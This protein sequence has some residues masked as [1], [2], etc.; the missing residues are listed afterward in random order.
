MESKKKMIRLVKS[1]YEGSRTSVGS[2]IVN[3]GKFEIRVGVH[4]GSC[5]N[6]SLLFV[7]VMDAISEH[8]RREVPWDMLYADDLRLIVADK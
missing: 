4:H 8:V 2:R 3:T 6:Y 5:L 7:I 1:M